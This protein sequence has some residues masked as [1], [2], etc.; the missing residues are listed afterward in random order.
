M[1][2]GSTAATA[3]PGLWEASTGLGD[4]VSKLRKEYFSFDDR[5]YFRNE[6]LPF[7]TGR[8]WDSVF[9]IHN[10]TIVPEVMP[11]LKAYEDSLTA[12]ARTVPFPEALDREPLAIRRAAF[13]AEVVENQLPVKILDG[14]LIVGGQFNSAMSLAHTRKE[15]NEYRRL[16]EE[17]IQQAY[18]LDEI[19]IGNC[20]AVPGHLIPDYRKMLQLGLRGMVEEIEG[21]MDGTDANADAYRR[22]QIMAARAVPRLAARYAAEAERIAGSCEEEERRKELLEIA[23]ICRKVPWEPPNTLHEAL[24]ALW[25]VHMLVMTEEG[26]PGPGLSLG[27]VDQTLCPFLLKDMVANRLDR[28]GARELLQCWFL[29]HNYAYDYQGRVG[30]NQGITAGYGQL[31]TIG[32]IDASGNDASNEM[33]WLMLDVIEDMNLLEPKPNV[34]LHRKTP[35][36]L[37]KRVAQMIAGAQGSPFLLNFDEHSIEGLRWQ[38]LP[39]EDLWDYAPVGCLENTLQG[40]DRSGTVDVNLNLAKAVELALFDGVDQGTARR[41]GPK[42][43]EPRN[44]KIFEDFEDAVKR[45]LTSLLERIIHVNNKADAIRARFQPTPYLSLLVDGCARNGKDVTAGGALHNYLTVEGIALG[46]T[47]DSLLAVKHLVFEEGRVS[48]GELLEAVKANF[49]G[50]ERT[51]LLMQN[52]AP[53]YGNDDDG[54]DDMARSLHRFW[55]EET[56]RHESP[57][58]GKRYRS[59]YLSWNYWVCYGPRT[60]ATPDGRARG[61]FLSNGSCPVTGVDSNGP[62]ANVRSVGKL[63]LETAPNGDSHTI[64]LSPSLLRDDEHVDKLAA[65]LRA[66]NEEGGTALQVNVI[67]PET[68]KAAQAAPDEYR[69]LLV[70]VTGYNAYFVMLGKEIQDEIISRESHAM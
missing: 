43:G 68:L 19:G 18:E 36:D 50:H 49:E 8:A 6:V 42:T 13:F 44:F 47:V 10:W 25:F 51:R 2:E 57:A 62:T 40:N 69:N 64:S 4:R 28:D 3:H 37:M 55:T 45:Q 29:K 54:A 23:R 16:E 21:F 66:Y 35:D 67:D 52:K 26:Y 70:R 12:C 63:G 61:R 60:A 38:G 14:E 22:A 32:G 27:R 15:A 24:Q 59:G 17:F 53:K 9:A 20:G 39:E 30:N 41:I 31:I 58:T 34:R 33:T 1:S 11:F 56:A 46:T 48:M 5:P 65:F 7:G